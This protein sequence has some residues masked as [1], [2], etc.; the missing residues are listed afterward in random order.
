[1][2]PGSDDEGHRDGDEEGAEYVRRAIDEKADYL[3]SRLVRGLERAG[4][5]PDVTEDAV[6]RAFVKLWHRPNL[7]D[8][9]RCR[10]RPRLDQLQTLLT[11][12]AR[13]EA[14]DELRRRGRPSAPY[15]HLGP[16]GPGAC[17]AELG[18]ATLV[19]LDSVEFWHG[20]ESREVAE[21]CL[22]RRS[23]VAVARCLVEEGR[24]STLNG[25]QAAVCRTM[26]RFKTYLGCLGFVVAKP[27]EQVRGGELLHEI[28]DARG[29]P[30]TRVYYR[31]TCD[32]ACVRWQLARGR[33]LVVVTGADVGNGFV[34]RVQLVDGDG[35][36][37]G[38]LCHVA[39]G[40]G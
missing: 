32:I 23:Q 17:D 25:A 16:D 38:W 13:R 22:R 8:P 5:P 6:Q 40:G 11:V 3:F 2:A 29:Q 30:R 19:A 20:G 33:P 36:P 34:P 7:F 26:T 39:A 28:R 24:H 10:E 18:D 4:L 14:F 21:A 27:C 15:P 1:M 12:I 37:I 9:T 31:P 35:A